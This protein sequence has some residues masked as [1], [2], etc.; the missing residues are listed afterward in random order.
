[1]GPQLVAAA[2]GRGQRGGGGQHPGASLEASRTPPGL[3]APPPG[4]WKGGVVEEGH[5][6]GPGGEPQ[7]GAW[8]EE[9][10][11]R[12]KGRKAARLGPG[13]LP[14]AVPGA[15]EGVDT[16]FSAP[17]LSWKLPGLRRNLEWDFHGFHDSPKPQNNPGSKPPSSW[18][19]S[20]ERAFSPRWGHTSPQTPHVSPPSDF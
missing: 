18:Q 6:E 11:L 15:R 1:M 4:T 7:S 16:G 13:T 19:E 12:V 10:S 20:P 8:Q 2:R 5:A 3:Q 9:Q 17:P 14:G